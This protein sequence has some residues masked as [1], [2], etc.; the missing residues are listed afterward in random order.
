MAV[1]CRASANPSAP[2]SISTWTGVINLRRHHRHHRHL[3][4]LLQRNKPSPME[5]PGR[6]KP[7]HPFREQGVTWSRHRCRHL[8]VTRW[9]GITIPVVRNGMISITSAR[10]LTCSPVPKGRGKD[11]NE[12]DCSGARTRTSMRMMLSWTDTGS[13]G[14]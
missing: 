3:P 14:K 6:R 9:N 4:L 11:P 12:A 8:W 5:A 10:A 13:L 1:R 7:G 2:T